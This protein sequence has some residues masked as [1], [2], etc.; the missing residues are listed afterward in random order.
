METIKELTVEQF[1]GV[2]KECI[3]EANKKSNLT[4]YEIK[5]LVKRLNEKINLPLISEVGE[6]KILTKIVVKIDNYL[7]ENLPDEFYDLLR[8]SNKGITDTEAQEL[9]DRLSKIA[10]KEINIPYLPEA[11]ERIA[12]KFVIKIIVESA[13]KQCLL[14]NE[15]EN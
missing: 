12:I 11:V 6:E 13:R 9:I 7:S 15:K 5:E 1:K 3:E 10:N 8:D 4:D 14:L 2:I